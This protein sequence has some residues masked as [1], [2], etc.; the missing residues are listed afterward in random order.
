M[1]PA[2]QLWPSGSITNSTGTLHSMNVIKVKDCIA[3]ME[4]IGFSFVGQIGFWYHFRRGDWTPSF[5]LG[6]LRHAVK[7]GF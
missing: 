1:E 4:S 7:F 2:R 3:H 6:E 5:G